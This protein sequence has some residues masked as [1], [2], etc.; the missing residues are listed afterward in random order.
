MA[1]L[2][3]VCCVSAACLFRLYTRLQCVFRASDVLLLS[4]CC[5][6]YVSRASGVCML[7]VYVCLLYVRAVC[8]CVSDVCVC[9]VFAASLSCMFV[10]ATRV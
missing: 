8:V 4:V 9:C 3:P 2:R 6:G 1:R 5:V 7:F 10:Y